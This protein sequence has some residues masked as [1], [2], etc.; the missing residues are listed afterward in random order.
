VHLIWVTVPP[1]VALARRI[2]RNLAR[3]AVAVGSVP[4][5]PAPAPVVE[6]L[7][8]SGSAEPQSEA[9]RIA[10]LVRAAVP[11]DAPVQP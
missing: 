1:E 2:R 4:L 5:P 11:T 8:A 9:I 3:D 6:H 7:A 10:R